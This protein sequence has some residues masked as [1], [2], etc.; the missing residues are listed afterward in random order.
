MTRT[1]AMLGTASVLALAAATAAQAGT[2]AGRVMDGSRT[3]GLE[4]ATIRIVETGQTVAAG[5]DGAFRI[6]GLA[7]GTYTLRISYVGAE[8]AETSVTLASVTDTATPVIVIGED[9]DYV[10]NILVV[11]QRG[12][13]NSAL[14]R[15]RAN[16]GNIVVLSADAIASSRTRTSPRPPAAPSA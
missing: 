12:A 1:F 15:Q 7:A 10:D 14:S 6:V 4:G 5:S 9:V 11:G 3:V 8:P 2:I 13:L 16:D